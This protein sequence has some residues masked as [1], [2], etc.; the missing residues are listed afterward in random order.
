MHSSMQIILRKKILCQ[1]ELFVLY[2]EIDDLDIII[3]ENFEKNN[4]YI[5]PVELALYSQFN[6]IKP[7]KENQ[8]HLSK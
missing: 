6:T 5:H 8:F 3:N 1:P 7:L 2:S 4:W